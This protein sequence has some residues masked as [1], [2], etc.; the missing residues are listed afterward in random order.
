MLEKL[1]PEQEAL[2]PVV[3]DQWIAAALGGD[4]SIDEAILTDWLKFCYGLIKKDTPPFEI[5]DGP[6]DAQRRANAKNGNA[7]LE[8]YPSGIGLGYDSGW[9]AFYDYFTRIGVINDANF[10]AWMKFKA[11]GIWD[12]L[13]FERIA[14][15]IRRPVTVNKDE[16][17]RLHCENGGAVVFKNGEKYYSWH[18]TRVPE[19]L[20][21][22]SQD[23]TKEDLLAERNAEVVR[24]WGEKL[25]WTK[26]LDTIGAVLIDDATDENTG[27]RYSLYD[28]KERPSDNFARFLKMESPALNDGTRPYYVEPVHPGLKSAMAARKWKV[29]ISPDG[30][31]PSAEDCNKNPEMKF[32]VEC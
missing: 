4:T 24:A 31:R 23:V 22:A 15:V 17:G 18:G 3:R 7:K 13:L 1:S 9:T 5:C 26:F 29:A 8:S 20:I 6:M 28:L 2:M 11:A 16:Q 25:G 10:N 19:R 21:M 30:S 12:C 32:L 14:Y 27:L